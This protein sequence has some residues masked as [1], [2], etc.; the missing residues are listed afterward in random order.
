MQKGLVREGI[1]AIAGHM[2]QLN[3]LLQEIR[4]NS[5]PASICG[6]FCLLF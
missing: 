6:V 2:L 1:M 5:D 4:Y 3:N